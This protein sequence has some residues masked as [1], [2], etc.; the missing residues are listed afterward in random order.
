MQESKNLQDEGN[1]RKVIRES[2]EGIGRYKTTCSTPHLQKKRRKIGGPTGQEIERPSRKTSE[3]F[4]IEKN[5]TPK[6]KEG[7][8]REGTSK[9]EC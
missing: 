5:D 4:N 1:K 6:E 9:R 3:I 2:K 7:Q 8:G